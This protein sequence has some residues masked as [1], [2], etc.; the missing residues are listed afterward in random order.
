VLPV[1]VAVVSNV[2]VGVG[3]Q[4]LY[5]AVPWQLQCALVADQAGVQYATEW[6]ARHVLV[7]AYQD[8]GKDVTV[9]A[10]I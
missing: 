2:A 3:S 4:V 7:F 8:A 6:A 1:R 9:A 5:F 10:T